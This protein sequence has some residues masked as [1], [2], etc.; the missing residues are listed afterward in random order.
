[1]AEEENKV[2]ASAG[3]GFASPEREGTGGKGPSSACG[4]GSVPPDPEDP[5]EMVQQFID[6]PADDRFYDQMARTFIEEYLMMGWSDEEIFSLF[7]EPFYRGTHDILQKKGE[8]FVK[9]LIHE[10]RH[11]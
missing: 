10:V 4:R 11:G 9:S 8:A 3:S 7:Q 1:M 6:V 2:S 5:F